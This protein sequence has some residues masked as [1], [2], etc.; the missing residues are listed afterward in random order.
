MGG[1]VSYATVPATWSLLKPSLVTRPEMD[2]ESADDVLVCMNAYPMA[3]TATRPIT[4]KKAMLPQG[5]SRCVNAFFL[6]AFF[7]GEFFARALP[8]L[9]AFLMRALLDMRA[10]LSVVLRIRTRGQRRIARRAT[11][12][13]GRPYGRSVTAGGPGG[14]GRTWPRPGHRAAARAPSRRAPADA[15][16]AGGTRRPARGAGGTGA[17]PGR[18]RRPSARARG[19]VRAGQHRARETVEAAGR[20]GPFPCWAWSPPAETAPTGTLTACWVHTRAGAPC[21][22]P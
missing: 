16:A 3:M 13:C 14:R 2:T 1:S 8:L 4:P 19:L 7:L 17:R 12:Q 5:T 22:S 10:V 18:G 20:P 15:R 9:R 6:G 11:R 21:P